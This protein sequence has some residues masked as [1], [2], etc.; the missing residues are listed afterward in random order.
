VH[1][2]AGKIRVTIRN[3]KENVTVA[4]KG[5]MAKLC[6][7]QT[8][9]VESNVVTSKI[10]DEWDAAALFVTEEEEDELALT[11]TLYDQI[12]YEKDWIV[13]SGCS[14]HMTGDKEKL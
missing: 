3:L 13:D 2:E 14:N 11:A 1:W 12:D 4:K 7:L 10:K 6:T 9:F 5:H 8:K